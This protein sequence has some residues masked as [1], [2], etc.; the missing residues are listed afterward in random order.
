MLAIRSLQ[1]RLDSDP[2]VNAAR[3]VFNLSAS[4]IGQLPDGRWIMCDR[5]MRVYAVLDDA[6]NLS[7]IHADRQ[8]RSIPELEAHLTSHNP[9]YADA[10]ILSADAL[11]I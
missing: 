7:V 8:L 5:A 3:R 1:G 9:A 10:P 4:L 6:P 11:E 2:D